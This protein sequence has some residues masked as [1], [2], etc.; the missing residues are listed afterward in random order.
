MWMLMMMK[1]KWRKTNKLNEMDEDDNLWV[2]ERAFE[3]ERERKR[4]EWWFGE[5]VKDKWKTKETKTTVLRSFFCL[6]WFDFFF[7]ETKRLNKR[8]KVD[9]RKK[10]K[11]RKRSEICCKRRR[12][13]RIETKD[14]PH[15][16]TTEQRKK[17]KKTLKWKKTIWN[18]FWLFVC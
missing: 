16:N 11:R 18:S 9:E 7:W 4:S 8:K 1:K 6:N 13:R 2:R 17:K 5:I 15:D 12:R 14:R 3:R 10:R